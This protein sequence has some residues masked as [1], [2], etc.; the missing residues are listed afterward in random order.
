M[1]EY[2]VLGAILTSALYLFWTQKLS[3][4]LIAALVL[5]CLILPWPHPD[6]TWE[7]VLTYQEAFSGFGSSAV[8]MI[9]AMFIF[10]G[11]LVQT[12][13]AEWA[14]V[15][16]FRAA[17]KREWMLQLTILTA[18]TLCSMFVNDTTTVLVFMPLIL[19]VCREKDLVPSRY[20]MFAAYGS[21]L[22]GQWTLIG[23]RSNI[24]I[25]DFYRQYTGEGL[26][27]FDFTPMAAGIF[28]A[29][30][31]YL[32]AFGRRFLPTWG[33]EERSEETREYLAEVLVM[34]SSSSV[35]KI[36]EDLDWSKRSDLAIIDAL[37]QGQRIP[38]W[39]RLEPGDVL[40]MKGPPHTIQEL[41]K[42][43]DFQLVGEVKMDQKTLRSVNLVTVEA[44]LAPNSFY[45]GATFAQM[46][47]SRFYRFTLIGISRNGET[48][49]S[50]PTEIPLKY[51]DYLLLLGN[52]GDLPRL[53]SNPNLILLGE[54][55]VPA[56]GRRKAVLT[57][58]LLAG[59]IFTAVTGLFAP[60]VSIPLAALLAIL[61]GCINLQDA[62][63]NIDLPT[64]ITLG[65]MI[66][67]G[68][69]LEK[70]GAAAEIAHLLVSAFHHVS[71]FILL[72]SI[73]LLA[74]LLTQLIENAAVAIILAP[75]AYQVAAET[76]LN[77]K[78][79]MVG[80]AICVSSAF[81]T[82]VAHESTILVLGPGR[83]R[84]HH[85]LQLGSILAVLT[86]LLGTLLTPL[87]WPF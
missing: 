82:P 40:I 25:N 32:I 22:G 83:Y 39:F 18:T 52:V 38:R 74:V 11:A 1:D 60:P 51:G 61:L 10:G 69:A 68:L 80:L 3:Y 46:D 70:T 53:R 55:S 44:L 62:Y 78:P 49:L 57:L 67:L 72:A 4:E 7:S 77:P 50:R 20:L 65:G 66:P 41:L 85:Y 30:A 87:V 9:A 23:T 13:A 76:S 26:G 14:G 48:L 5:I 6:G 84:F 19:T 28:L 73:L 54:K 58:S 71:P 29:S 21:L 8:I 86:W 35:G 56:I 37:R 59:I 2:L 81:C 79:F 12:G 43:T 27:F 16:L 31:F 15:R 34:E 24:L 17:S 47:F 42:S 75:L 64:I 45:Q 33:K 63:K 36:V